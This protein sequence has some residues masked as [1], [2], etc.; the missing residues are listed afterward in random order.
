MKEKFFICLVFIILFIPIIPSCGS[1]HLTIPVDSA[2]GD[3]VTNRLPDSVHYRIPAELQ[4]DPSDYKDESDPFQFN[5]VGH[6]YPIGW[7]GDGKFAYAQMMADTVP[8]SKNQRYEIQ[9]RDLIKDSI[10]WLI[11]ERIPGTSYVNLDLNE[12]Y[13]APIDSI[14][15][16]HY[17][18]IAL[19]LWKNNIIQDSI[20]TERKYLGFPPYMDLFIE[21]LDYHD[22]EHHSLG[23]QY[24]PEVK[25][26]M[27]SR[28]SGEKLQF[29]HRHFGKNGPLWFFSNGYLKDP[30]SSRILILV[31]LYFSGGQNRGV[32]LPMYDAAGID[33]AV[34]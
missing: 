7:S 8:G 20:I 27:G 25:L 23:Y 1:D 26:S 30:Y 19:A 34:L 3:S 16:K 12:T 11:T 15:N 2:I 17:T 28:K 32:R 29:Y 10:V 13:V 14:W 6:F 5:V 18:E 31:E 33:P 24:W 9:I 21:G 22:M 4:Y